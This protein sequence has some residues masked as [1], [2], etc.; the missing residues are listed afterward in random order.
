MEDSV[1]QK[2]E[3]SYEVDGIASNYNM[4]L[5][6]DEYNVLN[7]SMLKNHGKVDVV[8]IGLEDLLKSDFCTKYHKLKINEMLAKTN[9]INFRLIS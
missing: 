9:N 7:S 2:M 1:K 3:F 4:Q 5:S 6:Q 8:M